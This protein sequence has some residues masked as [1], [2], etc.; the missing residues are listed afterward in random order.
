M[1]SI[2]RKEQDWDTEKRMFQ[3]GAQNSAACLAGGA[4]LPLVVLQVQKSYAFPS[5]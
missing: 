4:A 2:F 3:A 5:L 1:S